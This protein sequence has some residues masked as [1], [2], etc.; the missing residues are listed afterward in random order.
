MVGK[1]GFLVNL[2]SII[3]GCLVGSFMKVDIDGVVNKKWQL[4]VLDCK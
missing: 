2:E 1:V 3:V 4:Q